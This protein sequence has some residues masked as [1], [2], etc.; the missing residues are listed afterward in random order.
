MGDLVQ[1]PDATE[2]VSV[3][4]NQDMASKKS[5]V[6]LACVA[7]LGVT[8]LL[9]DC[10]VDPLSCNNSSGSRRFKQFDFLF[11]IELQIE[12]TH[13]GHLIHCHKQCSKVVRHRYMHRIVG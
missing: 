6:R 9:A 12:R 3:G 8:C 4:T 13:D 11:Y 10:R 1:A 7:Q 5:S 2:H